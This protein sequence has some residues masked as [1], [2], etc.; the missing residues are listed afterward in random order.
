MVPL[1]QVWAKAMS[2]SCEQ[3]LGFH[4]T[5]LQL[6]KK[7][8]HTHTHT[9]KKKVSPTVSSL[10]CVLTNTSKEDNEEAREELDHFDIFQP[11]T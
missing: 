8:T 9:T 6:K 4:Y 3:I 5:V 7:N 1:L 10:Y 2:L 11:R